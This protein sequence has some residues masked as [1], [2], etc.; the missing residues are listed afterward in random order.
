MDSPPESA[1]N[2]DLIYL[3][4]SAPMKCLVTGGA[5]FIGSHIVEALIQ[6]GDTVRVLDNLSTGKHDNLNSV[7]GRI[8]FLRGD[9]RN[10]HDLASAVTDIDIVFH[11]AALRSVPRSVDDPD[12]TNEINITGTLHLLLACREA[13]V[14]RLVYASSSSV[15]GDHLKYP[16]SETM[17]AAPISP[18]AVSKLA[19]EN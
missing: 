7:Q 18:Y 14:K 8:E 9:L 2:D 3:V 10:P 17:R 16:Q 11:E 6:R 13:K 1:G 5:G 19:G 4:K 12:S 15:Y